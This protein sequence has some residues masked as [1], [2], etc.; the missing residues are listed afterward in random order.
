VRARELWFWLGAA[1]LTAG[2]VLVAIAIAYYTKESSYSLS[3]G[4]QMAAA[5]GLFAL[6]FSSFLA[7][8]FGW[9]PWLRWQRF[10]DVIVRVQAL[11]IPMSPRDRIWIRLDFTNA[12]ADRT[13][14]IGAAYLIRDVEADWR[15]PRGQATAVPIIDPSLVGSPLRL[16]VN[17]DPGTSAG[18]ELAYFLKQPDPLQYDLPDG[19]RIEIHDAVSGRTVIFPVMVGEYRRGHGLTEVT[20][21]PQAFTPP[22][23][24][25]VRNKSVTEAS[26][27]SPSS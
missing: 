21:S 26:S 1:C 16:P 4:P 22:R 7:A 25:R 17:L 2:G 18:G 9:R 24:R 11:A 3:T 10:P 19:A 6:A 12:E 20:N 5:Y 14:S 13:V 23:D 8:I 27:D 15:Y